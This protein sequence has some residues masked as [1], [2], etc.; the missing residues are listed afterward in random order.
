MAQIQQVTSLS[1]GGR[2]HQG[3]GTQFARCRRCRSVNLVGREVLVEGNRNLDVER[4]PAGAGFAGWPGVQR[5]AGGADAGRQWSSTPCSSGAQGADPQNF[6]W[7]ADKVDASW[8]RAQFRITATQGASSVA[9]TCL[10]VT[11]W[12]P[13]PTR[14][15][16]SF[17][18][19]PPGMTDYA[20]VL[21]VD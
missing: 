13:C 10:P 21:S 14:A 9:S 4:P 20:S 16:P 1:H 7:P 12:T 19:R 8:H 2:Q 5:A 11:A 15:A 3:L 18:T 17:A 6:T